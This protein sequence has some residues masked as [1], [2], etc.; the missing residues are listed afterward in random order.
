MV[1]MID[2]VFKANDFP[3]IPFVHYLSVT[4]VENDRLVSNSFL[5]NLLLIACQFQFMCFKLIYF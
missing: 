1:D 3:A 2:F 5:F 4:N